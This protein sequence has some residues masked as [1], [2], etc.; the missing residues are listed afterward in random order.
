MC[1]NADYFKDGCD[2]NMVEAIFDEASKKLHD[3]LKADVQETIDQYK[4]AQKE[5]AVL[6]K[7]IALLKSQKR[8]LEQQVSKAS[9]KAEDAESEDAESSDIPAKYINKIVKKYTGFYAPGDEVWNIEVEY[10]G[11]TCSLCHGKKKVDATFM[12]YGRKKKPL[13]E[14]Q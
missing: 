3:M 10:R 9:R 7:D 11:N 14:K 5:Q 6:E 1:F 8:Y 13:L 12:I 4:T 2:A